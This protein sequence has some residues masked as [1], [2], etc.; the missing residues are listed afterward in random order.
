MEDKLYEQIAEP[1]DKAGTVNYAIQLPDTEY[2]VMCAVWEGPFPLTTAWLMQ[3][4]GNLRGWKTPT[5][6]SFLCRLED[7]GFIGSVKK[8]RERYYFPLADK[9]I[10]LQETT[11]RFMTKYHNG[12]LVS[13]LNALYPDKRLPDEEIDTFIA[14]LR[15]GD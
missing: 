5:L 4:I 6:I 7:R 1:E 12:G 13:M 10:Y 15:C 9:E 3:E 2:D 11:K 14:W 8:G